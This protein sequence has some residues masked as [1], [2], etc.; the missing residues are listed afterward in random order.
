MMLVVTIAMLVIGQL[1]L[2]WGARRSGG[3]SAGG[4]AG[5]ITET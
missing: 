1:V 4:M 3:G 5:M 2:S